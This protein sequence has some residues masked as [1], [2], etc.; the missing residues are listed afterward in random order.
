MVNYRKHILS[1][2]KEIFA[3]RDSEQNDLLVSEA[4]RNDV[5][6]HTQEPGSPFVNLGE[7]PSR[8]EIKEGAVFCALKSQDWRDTQGN[9]KV[10]VFL[11][12]D[13][14][15]AG[16]MKGGT[17]G[18]KKH[19]ETINVKKMNILKLRDEIELYKLNS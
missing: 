11:K 4:K 10:N 2:G 8:D 18:V 16:G 6:L 19:S 12:G 1:T 5:L 9:I 14:Y 3:G 17:W 13:C 15:K 7:K